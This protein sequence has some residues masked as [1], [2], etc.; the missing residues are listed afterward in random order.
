MKPLGSEREHYWLALSMAKA[1]GVDLQAA[2]DDGRFDQKSWAATVQRC[3]GCE[4]GSECKY[5]LREHH[6]IDSAPATCA[7]AGLF[8]DLKALKEVQ[9][10][11]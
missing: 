6:E 11:S 2:I 8:D 1:A 3:R 10:P 5:W 4:W 9:K 7:N